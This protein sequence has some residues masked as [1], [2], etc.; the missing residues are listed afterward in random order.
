M[1]EFI[2]DCRP[3]LKEFHSLLF[4]ACEANTYF[5]S[6]NYSR[7][8]RIFSTQQQLLFTRQLKTTVNC[9]IDGISAIVRLI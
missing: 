7:A 2:K 1:K 8:L 4:V 6:K 3:K 9:T 5:V